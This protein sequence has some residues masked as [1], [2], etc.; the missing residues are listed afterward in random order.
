MRELRLPRVP[1]H[2]LHFIPL[3][4]RQPRAAAG[5]VLAGR[6][7]PPVRGHRGRGGD[8]AR[9]SGGGVGGGLLF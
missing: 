8:R 2:R 1:Q 5:R 6:R 4:R 9:P 3:G 7:A